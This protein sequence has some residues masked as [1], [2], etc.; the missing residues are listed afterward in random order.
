MVIES[1]TA[2]QKVNQKLSPANLT[3]TFLFCYIKISNTNWE[4]RDKKKRKYMKIFP[5]DVGVKR[6]KI[7]FEG[8]LAIKI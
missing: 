1:M 6:R 5:T 8:K 2:G 4:V 3:F 7:G